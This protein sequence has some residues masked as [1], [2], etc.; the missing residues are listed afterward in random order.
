M[1]LSLRT[2]PE[3]QVGMATGLFAVARGVAGTLGV[4]FS[5]SFLEYRREVHGLWLAEEQGLRELPSQWVTT[6]LQQFF[7]AEGDG[8]SVAQVRGAAHLHAMLQEEASIAAYQDVFLCSAFLSLCALLPGLLRTSA[9]R[10]P[11]GGA[12]PPT[13]GRVSKGGHAGSDITTR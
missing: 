7:A 4:A 10:T 1:L 12:E 3:A 13:G 9:R 8:R 5:A 6:E 2:I 11:S